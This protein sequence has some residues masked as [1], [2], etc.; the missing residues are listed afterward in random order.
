MTNNGW[1]SLLGLAQRAGKVSSGEET[2]LRMIRQGKAKAVILSADASQRTKKTIGNK[3]SYYHV[4]LLT[5]PDREVLGQAIGQPSR[6]IIAVT[7]SGFAG[8]LIGRI[9]PSSRG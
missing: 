3:C 8:Q 9:G 6:V 1:Q 4:P 5:V 7:D 2:V